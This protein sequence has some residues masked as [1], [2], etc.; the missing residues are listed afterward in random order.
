MR[1]NPS[2][3][4]ILVNPSGYILG[5]ALLHLGLGWQEASLAVFVG[6]SVLVVALIANGVAGARYGIPFPVLAR[7]AFGFEGAKVV[8][9]L[10]ATGGGVVQ[11]FRRRL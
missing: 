9:V 11:S 3:V 10:L 4:S 7:A 1:P 8:A 6:S 2:W 5:A